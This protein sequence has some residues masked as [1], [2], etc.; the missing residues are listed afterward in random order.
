MA[1]KLPRLFVEHFTDTSF[2]AERDATLAGFLAGFIS[3]LRPGQACIHFAGVD[4]AAAGSAACSI[5]HSS[6][7][8]R[9]AAASWS[10]RS[11]PR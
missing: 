3:Q 10:A 9:P 5:R 2:A 4:P 11:P 1:D 7:L 6:P 8:P